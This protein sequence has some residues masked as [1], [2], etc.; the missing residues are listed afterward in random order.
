MRPC[1]LMSL[2]WTFS[3]GWINFR[4][5]IEQRAIIFIKLPVKTIAQDARLLGT[6]LLAEIHAAI[7]S[8]ADIP[9]AQRP[10]FSLYVDEFQHFATS[11]FSEMLTEGRKFGV[12]VTVAHQHRSQV[13]S[14]LR[15]STMTTRTKV[16][17]RLTPEDSREMAHVFP[18]DEATVRPEDIAVQSGALPTHAS[19]K[20]P[21]GA[22]IY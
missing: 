9:A 13:P 11:D 1:L 19:V 17:F 20:R 22:G 21:C 10:G 12:R 8:F 2:V 4:R 7:F 18:S 16:C 14:F 6:I 5:A 15:D 3:T